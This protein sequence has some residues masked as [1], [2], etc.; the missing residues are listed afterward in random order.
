M[1]QP[2]KNASQ[3]TLDNLIK[4]GPEMIVIEGPRKVQCF[5]WASA[6]LLQAKDGWSGWFPVNEIEVL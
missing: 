4:H 2:T 3:R 1:I 5:N 6:L